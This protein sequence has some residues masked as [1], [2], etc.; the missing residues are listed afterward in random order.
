MYVHVCT[1][2][3]APSTTARTQTCVRTTLTDFAACEEEEEEAEVAPSAVVGLD[4]DPI[5]SAVRATAVLE[6]TGAPV[7]PISLTRAANR[8]EGC[9]V[10]A[11]FF[12]LRARE[13]NNDR[14]L[15][16]T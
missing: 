13:S 14:A 11:V 7:W 4:S 2:H 3:T 6:N 15:L 9:V 10:V 5:C 1:R 8:V 16:N 12:I